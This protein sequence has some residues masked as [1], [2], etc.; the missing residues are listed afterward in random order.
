ME[1]C[2][3]GGHETHARHGYDP[4]SK[5]TNCAGRAAALRAGEVVSR[6]AVAAMGAELLLAGGWGAGLEQ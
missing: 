1:Y 6:R 2:G 5:E 4:G 3:A